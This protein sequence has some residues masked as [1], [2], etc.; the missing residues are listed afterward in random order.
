M[1][2]FVGIIFAQ[3]IDFA[4]GMSIA[5]PRPHR[6]L[7][8]HGS[9]RDDLRNILAPVF[10]VT[11]DHLLPAPHAEININIGHG[12]AFWIQ[13]RFKQQIVLQRVHVVMRSA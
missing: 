2:A 4:V 10:R 8:G 13:E 1:R 3:A 12:H 5:R 7:R 9:Q 6:G 11:I